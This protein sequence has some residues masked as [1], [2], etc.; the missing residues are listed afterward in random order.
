MTTI[1]LDRLQRG[2]VVAL[3]GLTAAA[4][5]WSEQQQ[6]RGAGD[7]V[8]LKV[9]TGPVALQEHAFGRPQQ[10][11]S[12]VVLR[13]TAATAGERIVIPLN[14]FDYRH[15]VEGG[16]DASDVR[17][18]L[19][20]DISEGEEG[21]IT[22]TADGADGIRLVA[23]FLGGILHIGP[24][25]GSVEEDEGER[26][27]TGDSVMVREAIDYF[28]VTVDCFSKSRTPRHGATALAAA[29]RA[30]F[31]DSA[32]IEELDRYGVALRDRGAVR[33]LAFMAGGNWETRASFDL[34]LSVASIAISP[35]E[36][37][38]QGD[39]TITVALPVGSATTTAS[40]EAPA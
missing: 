25:G 2:L 19:L 35:V 8:E 23:D 26:V 38:E 34:Y 5:V 10:P 18:A 30:R 1:R 27:S 21:A 4:P 28:L 24:L 3:T 37:I 7:L 13:V 6:P 14:G 29:A 11:P 16:E 33:N 20:V 32:R 36:V 22:A 15:D 40:A 9:V 12:T 17:D 39:A 31:E